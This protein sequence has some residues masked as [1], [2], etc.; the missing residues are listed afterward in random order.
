[1]QRV[2]LILAVIGLTM[3]SLGVGALSAH[4]P[5]WQRAWQWHAA[6]SGWP[7]TIAGATHVLRG[8]DRALALAVHADAGI[9]GVAGTAGTQALLRAH[10]D[11]R[12]EA[13]FAPGFELRSP[14]D[15]RGLAAVLLVPLFAQLSGEH[16][17]V[18]DTPVAA[19]LT[20]WKEDRRGMITPRQLFWQLSGLP[21]RAFNPLN[22]FAARAQLASG[23][24]FAR[25]VM[26]WQPDYPPATHFEES[27]VNAQLLA[28]VAAAMDGAPFRD[29]VQKRLWSQVAADDALAMLD[30]RRG[31]MAVHCCLKASLA[32][33]LR[34]ALL[35]AT[36]GRHND[37][38]LW[39]P[40]FISQLVA[41][42]PVHEGYGLGFQLRTGAAGPLLVAASA[43]R[44]LWIAPQAGT[45]L[46][47]VGE[48]APPPGMPQLL[49]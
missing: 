38:A 5:F 27:P 45:V 37:A 21:A 3:A 15:G 23:P 18:L 28:L 17:G 46:L 13:W 6:P 42:S 30:H 16:P 44:Q 7:E 35:L 11:G 14:V 2:L 36:D 9:A 33:W 19:W 10:R 47:W 43:G 40:G 25:A 8:A 12:V 22:P 41:A 26:R 31:D 49:R 48:G 29:V 34:L 24:D 39:P 32:D 4:W 20:D 1:M